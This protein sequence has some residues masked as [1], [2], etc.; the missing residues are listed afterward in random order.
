MDEATH[1]ATEEESLE[2]WSNWSGNLTFEPSRIAKPESEEEVQDLVEHCLEEGKTLRVVGAG[3]SW[4]PVVQTDGLLVSLEE[5]TGLVSHDPDAKTAVIRG[6]TT[7]EEAASALQEVNLAM[8]N[9][10]DVSLQTVAGAF[11]TGTHGTGADLQSLSSMLVGGRIVTGTGEVKAF[12][13][14][15]DPEF[16]KAARLS[17]GALGVFTE[18]RLDLEPAYKIQR[19]EYC[20]TAE[21]ALE[22]VPTLAEENR[23]FD[24][25]W[26]PRSDEVKLRLLNA[27]N[28]GT[29]EAD[30][31]YATLVQK[32]TGWWHQTIAEHDDMTRKFEEM[33]Y[34]V[35]AEDGVECF[36]ELRDR[37]REEWRGDVGWRVLWRTIAPEDTYL[38]AEY[39]RQTVTMGVLQNAQ[40]EYEPYFED[41]E[42]IFRRYD[43]RPHWGKR[44][45]LRAPELSELY[46]EW[47]RF[48][49]IRREMDPERVFLSDYLRA[50]LE[51]EG[52]D[53]DEQATSE[54]PESGGDASE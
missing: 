43:G 23:H 50:L 2:E 5:M 7:L 26:Y 44:H 40:L 16:L 17:L 22:H 8:T 33:E 52:V 1:G 15:D 31:E 45:S 38:S 39:G 46:P 13:A 47:D 18:L 54:H 30:L 28:G 53:R 51:G 9:L 35:P 29:D 41:V 11:G 21:E 27:P 48:Q 20:T 19:R 42:E 37:I 14:E 24:F 6:G 36:L 34:A 3:H 10:G 12:S 25:Y 32:D 49:E 4:T